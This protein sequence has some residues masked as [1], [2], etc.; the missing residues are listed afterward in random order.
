MDRSGDLCEPADMPKKKPAQKR[1]A[2]KKPRKNTEREENVMEVAL[3]K[4]IVQRRP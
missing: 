2:K 1:P 4:S 3:V